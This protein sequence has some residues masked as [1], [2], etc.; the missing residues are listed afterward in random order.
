MVASTI[1]KKAMKSKPKGVQM[2]GT[3]SM[4]DEIKMIL[5]AYAAGNITASIRDLR[6]MKA[7]PG[8]KHPMSGRQ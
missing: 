1:L 2:A 3:L 6:L 5:D 4:T 8:G 7:D